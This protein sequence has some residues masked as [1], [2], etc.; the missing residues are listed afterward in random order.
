MLGFPAQAFSG[1]M[2]QA[3][4]D[5]GQFLLGDGVEGPGFRQVLPDEAVGISFVPR[6]REA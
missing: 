6:C 4:H 3:L 2:V 5:H 1:A